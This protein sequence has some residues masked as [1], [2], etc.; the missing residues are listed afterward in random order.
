MLGELI[1][2]AG[3]APIRL[4]KPVQVI[5]RHQDCDI[6]VGSRA[7]S[8]RHCEL[9]FAEGVWTVSDLSS[10]N[11]TLVNGNRCSHQQLKPH[12]RLAIGRVQFR[13]HWAA[14]SDSPPPDELAH[15]SDDARTPATNRNSDSDGRTDSSTRTALSPRN[16]AG[17]TPTR[18]TGEAA[19]SRTE[20]RKRLL[21]KLIPRG[22]GD[23]IPL[24]ESPLTIGRARECGIRLKQP[25]VSSRHCKLDFRDGYWFVD[26]LGSRNGI[27]ID[28]VVKESGCLMPDSTL[29]VARFRFQIH[30]RPTG[31]A[32][33]PEAH[34]FSVSLLEKAGLA[35]ALAGDKL[36]RWAQKDD[37][38]A[39]PRYE[40]QD[41]DS[42][43]N[44]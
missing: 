40:I 16:H 31:D 8:G 12:D 23:P 7:V 26:D 10:K 37:F 9:R 14:S 18:T 39:K 4:Y 24:L 44:P 17:P 34:L 19:S 28:D 11:G 36:P 3:G 20:S 29:S 30:Y 6:I 27:R 43:E 42:D 41:V 38:P 35:K 1:P 13:I 32:P 21:G 25:T 22:G 2:C 5:G 15:S 33:P